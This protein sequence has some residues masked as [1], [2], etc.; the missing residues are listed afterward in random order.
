MAR[1][2]S[3]QE[4]INHQDFLD[5]R[6]GKFLKQADCLPYLW[7]DDI[8][9]DKRPDL[10]RPC[11]MRALAIDADLLEKLKK[12]PPAREFM[13]PNWIQFS[14]DNPE[15]F[16]SLQQLLRM[17]LENNLPIPEPLSA[18]ALRVAAYEAKP[19]RREGCPQAIDFTLRVNSRFNTLTQDNQYSKKAAY[20]AISDEAR[21]S[22]EAIR[23]TVRNYTNQLKELACKALKPYS[24]RGGGKNRG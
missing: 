7:L 20:Q 8:P 18:W 24:K 6:S 9:Q 22:P 13:I 14:K 21:R 17:L 5:V 12:S 1:K 4:D 10:G 15:Y 19:K 16:V 3:P 2:L 23:S 11:K